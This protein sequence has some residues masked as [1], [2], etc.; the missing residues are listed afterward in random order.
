MTGTGCDARCTSSV[1]DTACEAGARVWAVNG[2]DVLAALW[3]VAADHP[4]R[5]VRVAA[6][7][8]F[9]R[10]RDVRWVRETF[11]RQFAARSR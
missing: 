4:D 2:G 5:A 6:R 10:C 8:A 1:Y 9:G 7:E 3:T 11:A